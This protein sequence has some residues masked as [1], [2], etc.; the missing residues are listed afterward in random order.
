[1]L[2][3]GAGAACAG[4]EEDVAEALAEQFP[5]V[6][7]DQ[8]S[9]S[10]IPGL[11]EVRMG[12]QVA[13]VTGDGQ[14]LV[15]GDIYD[16][17]SQQNITEASR[18]VARQEAVE[19][20]GESSMVIFEPKAA[21]HTVT[22]FTDIDCG[23][24]RKLHRQISEY[25]QRGIRVRYMFF[26]R[27]GPETESWFKAEHVWCS[28]DRNSALTRAKAGEVVEADDCGSTPVAQHYEM[29]LGIGI[30]GTPAILLESGEMVPGYM[31]PDD[32]VARLNQVP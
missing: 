32:L 8:I 19:D 11:Y 4:A 29:G 26:P 23:Y 21:K 3:L 1:M 15:Q 16:L 5:E 2:T 6:G 30:R 24:C 31:P 20:V 27:S 28:E 25:N 10:P 17:A 9:A 13:Y 14:Y 7:A 12:A 18:S 22:V